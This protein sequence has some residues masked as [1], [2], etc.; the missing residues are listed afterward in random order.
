MAAA[1]TCAP[2]SVATVSSSCCH[3]PLAGPRNQASAGCGQHPAGPLHPAPTA[4]ARCSH[5]RSSAGC[6]FV[7]QVCTKKREGKKTEGR[8][9]TKK[10]GSN[11][12]QNRRSTNKWIGSAPTCR[13]Y[14][15]SCRMRCMSSVLVSPSLITTRPTLSLCCSKWWQGIWGGGEACSGVVPQAGW[16]AAVAQSW[17]WGCATS[18][19]RA[20]KL[21]LPV[22]QVARSRV[23]LSRAASGS[24]AAGRAGEAQPT[25]CRWR[26]GEQWSCQLDCPASRSR[27]FLPASHLHIL[28]R[29]VPRPLVI[30]QAVVIQPIY[31]D[32]LH[33]VRR[34]PVP[35]HGQRAPPAHCPNT[36]SDRAGLHSAKGASVGQKMQKEALDQVLARKA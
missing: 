32:A 19:C 30:P 22:L 4:A 5:A 26:V 10:P 21:P 20:S 31:F 29:N 23:P 18:C 12:T 25:P 11:T 6:C 15:Q 3:L 27:A 2:T 1:V 34:H 33:S 35:T 16:A 36:Q 28:H 17:R 13:W 9:P 24:P 8:T 14:T 7:Q